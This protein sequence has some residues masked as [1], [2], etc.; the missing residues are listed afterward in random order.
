[1]AD[2]IETIRAA[3]DAF[4]R[5]DGSIFEYF[6]PDVEWV[7]APQFIE[8]APVRGIEGMR[9]LLE[10]YTEPFEEVHWI[11]VRIEKG[12]E[13]GLF[14]A[15]IDAEVRG[16][17]SGAEVGTR[18]AHLIRM[19]DGKLVWGRVYPNPSEGLRAAGVDPEPAT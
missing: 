18:V 19:R 17:G 6:D 10:T 13:E 16:A 14:V 1:L 15:V 9:R 4:N 12:A 5:G 8:N 11:P 3:Y 2:D 7:P